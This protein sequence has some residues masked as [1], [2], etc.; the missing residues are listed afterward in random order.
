LKI[1]AGQK[2]WEVMNQNGFS[3]VDVIRDHRSNEVE[4]LRA[5]LET[6]RKALQFYA[7]T[8]GINAIEALAQI[9]AGQKGGDRAE[10][11]ELDAQ[12]YRKLKAEMLRNPLYLGSAKRRGDFVF[13]EGQFDAGA[14]ALPEPEQKG[15]K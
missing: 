8:G 1:K 10:E 11:N 13:L 5:Q 15:G 12:R 9:G 4:H 6:A 2:G 14:D 3:E 7:D